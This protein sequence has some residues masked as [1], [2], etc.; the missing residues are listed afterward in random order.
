VAGDSILLAS[1]SVARATRQHIEA[2]LTEQTQ[3]LFKRAW[4]PD[5]VPG[6]DGENG[7]VLAF[8]GVMDDGDLIRS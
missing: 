6:V 2:L 7:L 5:N 3:H 8:I 1:V 4:Y